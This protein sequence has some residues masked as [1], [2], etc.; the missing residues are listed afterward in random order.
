MEDGEAAEE[1]EAHGHREEGED[2]DDTDGTATADDLVARYLLSDILAA[3]GVGAAAGGDGRPLA[4]TATPKPVSRLYRIVL[5][6][7]T[8]ECE[9]LARLFL[10]YPLRPPLLLVKGVREM[11]R[12][13]QARAVEDVNLVAWLEAEANSVALSCMPA[14]AANNTLLYQLLHLR[15]AFDEYAALYFAEASGDDLMA[16]LSSK[17]RMRGRDRRVV[18]PVLPE[19]A[20]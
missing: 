4:A 10:E 7:K 6:L 14:D 17:Q 2:G 18:L 19:I 5:K 13:G 12:R 1:G 15:L 3:E 9:I 16:L 20:A 11:A 8:L